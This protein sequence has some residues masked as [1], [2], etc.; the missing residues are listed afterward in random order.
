MS[1]LEIMKDRMPKEAVIV[2]VKEQQSR[3]DLIVEV[4]GK[5][6]KG[7]LPKT[8]APNMAERVVDFSICTLM[9]G[10]YL[11]NGNLEKAKFW[12]DKQ[13]ELVQLK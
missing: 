1:R 11:G 7:S 13:D 6:T 2:K 12:K 5:T 4:D 9:M 8:C 3:Y 10:A